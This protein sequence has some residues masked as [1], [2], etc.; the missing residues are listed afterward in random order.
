MFKQKS[1][2]GIREVKKKDKHKYRC[3]NTLGY[4]HHN[5]KRK[6]KEKGKK[7]EKKNPHRNETPNVF[8]K[9]LKTQFTHFH[10][11]R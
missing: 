5:S 2:E 1:E 8:H 11:G 3:N 10:N 7:K 9:I 4:L 6:K